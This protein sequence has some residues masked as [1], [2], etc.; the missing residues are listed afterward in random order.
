M[1]NGDEQGK[2]CQCGLCRISSS[3]GI[4]LGP[5]DA[6]DELGGRPSKYRMVPFATRA[7]AFKYP[8]DPF[9][10]EEGTKLVDRGETFARSSLIPNQPMFNST[11]GTRTPSVIIGINRMRHSDKGVAS[12]DLF[13]VSLSLR[14]NVDRFGLLSA[15][16]MNEKTAKSHT[17][18]R[19]EP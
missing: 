18:S 16:E 19:W 6:T 17:K 14:G 4:V 2:E 7:A 5:N 9:S 12:Q 13:A 8:S 10:C 1:F 15:Q 11:T 3:V